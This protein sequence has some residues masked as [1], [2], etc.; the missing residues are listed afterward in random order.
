MAQIEVRLTEIG[1][2][3]VQYQSVAA[4]LVL[5]DKEYLLES[6]LLDA[7]DYEEDRKSVV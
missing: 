3:Y 7:Q 2:G 6:V 1:E 4:F 5:R